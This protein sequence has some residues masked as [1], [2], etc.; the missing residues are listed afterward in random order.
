MTISI[1]LLI[2]I[3]SLNVSFLALYTSYK[4]KEEGNRL[5]KQGNTLTTRFL[6]ATTWL[7]D[8]SG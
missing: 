7:P 5:Q 1:D 4:Q 6:M 3:V 2:S 8:T